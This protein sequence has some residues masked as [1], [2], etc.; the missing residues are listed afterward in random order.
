MKKYALLLG[1]SYLGSSIA[2]E[3]VKPKKTDKPQI[4]AKQARSKTDKY[5]GA[6]MVTYGTVTDR[7]F[8]DTTKATPTYTI[9]AADVKTKV[10]ATTVEDTIRYA[11]GVLIRKRFMGDP[12]GTLGIRTSNTF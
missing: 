12:N 6:D 5:Q 4:T 3:P 11:P 10:N 9:D 8:P 2:A 7:T 1:V